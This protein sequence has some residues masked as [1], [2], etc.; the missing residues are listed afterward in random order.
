MEEVLQE[1]LPA[2]TINIVKVITANTEVKP[3]KKQSDFIDA[4]DQI[5]EINTEL[6]L[7]RVSGIE[8][9]YRKTFEFFY[10]KIIPECDHMT[11]SLDAQ[12]L[13]AFSISVHAMKSSLAMLGIMRLSELSFKLETASKENDFAYCSESYPKL[14]E[15]L[16]QL[17]QM[18]TPILRETV[19]VIDRKPGDMEY[20]RNNL[21]KA[22][23]AA[24]FY[25][26]SLGSRILADL[27]AYDFGETNN[28]LLERAAASFKDFE[29]DDAKEFLDTVN[30]AL[31]EAKPI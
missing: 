4:L 29:Y 20:L 9:M 2:H 23:E 27:L 26:Q 8:E 25:E 24:E 10:R 21:Q 22:L 11:S 1:W 19:K 3:V 5:N 31:G 18:L 15:R 28:D 6:G 16:L 12:N 30:L 7:G 13:K 14:R 17:H